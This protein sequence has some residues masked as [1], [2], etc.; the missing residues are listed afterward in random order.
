MSHGK[1]YL[2]YYLAD[3]YL[4][5]GKLNECALVVGKR[6]EFEIESTIRLLLNYVWLNLKGNDVEEALKLVLTKSMPR[7]EE[8]TLKPHLYQ[9]L[10]KVLNNKDDLVQENYYLKKL[11]DHLA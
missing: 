8:M 10:I 3:A 5:L 4:R 7:F 11:I 1:T 9:E 2:L 6:V